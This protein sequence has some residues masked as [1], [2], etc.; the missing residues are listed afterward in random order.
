MYDINLDLSSPTAG[1]IDHGVTTSPSYTHLAVA[2]DP[3]SPLDTRRMCVA[4][5]RCKDVNLCDELWQWQHVGL[6]LG[7][8]LAFHMACC[9]VLLV[10]VVCSCLVQIQ[11]A[12]TF[13]AFLDNILLGFTLGWKKSSSLNSFDFV[14]VKKAAYVPDSERCF[15]MYHHGFGVDTHWSRHSEPLIHHDHVWFM[16]FHSLNYSI[17][18]DFLKKKR[19]PAYAYILLRSVGRRGKIHSLLYIN[20]NQNILDEA[21]KTGHSYLHFFKLGRVFCLPHVS[22][23]HALEIFN[24]WLTWCKR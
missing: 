22:L 23:C 13:F 16:R 8:L 11:T 21:S 7:L 3:W 10:Y 17:L 2:H 5:G 6:L 20:S 19:S 9:L 18:V 24:I 4:A 1:G 12:E 15:P 14:G